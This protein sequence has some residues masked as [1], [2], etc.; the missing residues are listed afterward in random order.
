MVKEANADADV[1]LT[2]EWV[3]QFMMAGTWYLIEPQPTWHPTTPVTGPYP[4]PK[5]TDGEE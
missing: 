1:E 3:Q 4:S 5:L 2:E